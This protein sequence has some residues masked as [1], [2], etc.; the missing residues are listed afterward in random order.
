MRYLFFSALSSTFSCKDTKGKKKQELG[1]KA[2]T[3]GISPHTPAV[4]WLIQGV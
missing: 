1:E 2:I 4:V 3:A